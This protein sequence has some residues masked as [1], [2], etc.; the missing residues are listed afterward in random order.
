MQ[1]LSFS[2]VLFLVFLSLLSWLSLSLILDVLGLYLHLIFLCL[3]FLLVHLVHP[4]NLAVYSHLLSFSHSG[5]LCRST[6]CSVL[7][8]FK[9]IESVSPPLLSLPY[10]CCNCHSVALSLIILMMPMLMCAINI[11]LTL[12]SLS[13]I[14]RTVSASL[15]SVLSPFAFVSVYV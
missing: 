10:W 2:L 6:I 3:M 12:V 15:P 11:D 5:C 8:C 9:W 14:R 1:H 7:Y 13:S 4:L